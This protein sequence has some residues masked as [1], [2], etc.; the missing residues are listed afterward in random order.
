M[1]ETAAAPLGLNIFISYGGR[2]ELMRAARLL[3]DDV[4]AGRLTTEQIDEDTFGARLYTHTCPDPDLL[5]RTSGE[6]RL[7][8]FSV[9]AGCVRG[10]VHLER[11]VAR[12]WR[13]ALFEAI[14]DF[15][16]RDRRFGRVT[17]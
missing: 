3:A 13:V 7:S 15:Q 10:V 17:P 11:V 8:Q 12:L 16:R 4:K 1:R 14:V 5:I 2:A 9:V 6:Q